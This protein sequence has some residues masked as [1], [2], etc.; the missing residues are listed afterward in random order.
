[1]RRESLFHN[2]NNKL[3]SATCI[4]KF[5]KSLNRATQSRY[6]LLQREVDHVGAVRLLWEIRRQLVIHDLD[7]AVKELHV[8]KVA[9]ALECVVCV[10]EALKTRA[11]VQ[12]ELEHRGLVVRP[13]WRHTGRWFVLETRPLALNRL[14]ELLGQSQRLLLS[15]ARL[16]LETQLLLNELLFLQLR[17]LFTLAVGLERLLVLAVLLLTQD[18]CLGSA[19]SHKEGMH[20]SK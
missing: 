13:R 15:E 10:E 14:N 1:M 3:Q 17:D 11:I 8:N 5:N 18:L 4:C 20:I 19:Y 7:L 6:Q 12:V 16:L 9:N 2:N